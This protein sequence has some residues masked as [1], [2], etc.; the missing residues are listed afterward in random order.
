LVCADSFVKQ[1]L[2]TVEAGPLLS[3]VVERNRFAE[4]LDKALRQAKAAKAPKG[5]VTDVVADLNKVRVVQARLGQALEALGARGNAN[6]PET[7][8]KFSELSAQQVKA[9]QILRD[10]AARSKAAR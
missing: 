6:D 1:R 8:A 2:T 3:H 10:S 5:R 9:A 7:K 4:H